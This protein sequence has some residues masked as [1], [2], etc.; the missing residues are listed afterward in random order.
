[1][2]I[3]SIYYEPNFLKDWKKLDQRFRIAAA[4]A[5]KLFRD[6][7]LHPSLRLHAL[8][9][10][11]SG[12]WSI[13]VTFDLRIIFKRMENGDIVFLSIGRHEIYNK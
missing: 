4:K 11:L 8:Q 1:M 5:E 2:I 3:R 9:G 13:S 10:K 6:N 12:L 7:P